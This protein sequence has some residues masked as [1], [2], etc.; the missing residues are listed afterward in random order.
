MSTDLAPTNG[1]LPALTF[2]PDQLDL[3]K[4]TIC[5]GATDDELALFL[6]TAK[7]TGL[8][9]LARQI[10][11]V[12][13]WDAKAQRE[14]MTLQTGIDG[15]RLIA[16]RSGQHAGTDDAQFALDADGHALSAS[17]TV[18]RLVVG[19]RVPFAATARFDEYAQRK[20][21]GSAT[22]MWAKMPFLMIAK[23]AE[24]LA[25]RKAFPAEL[26]GVYTTEEMTQADAATVIETPI[27]TP[28]P[29]AVAA[30]S[31]VFPDAA[32]VAPTP[33][34]TPATATLATKVNAALKEID[35]NQ[36]FAREEL[37][38]ALLTMHNRND[39]LA[40]T[41]LAE[42]STFQGTNGVVLGV[43]DV[44]QLKAKRLWVMHDKVM[45]LF[46]A[47][48]TEHPDYIP[49]TAENEVPCE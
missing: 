13:R 33:S 40:R 2:T 17:V 22:S 45:K 47:W 12:K 10:Y 43:R 49:P 42:L 30:V 16:Q 46:A 18:Y 28:T 37:W 38:S 34:S 44:W 7:R 8:D 1:T 32:P 11:A 3:I 24:A 25:L 23:C 20:K 4:R 29:A 19:Q 48:Q 26:S 36:A 35:Q 15:Y 41:A 21:D 27:T 5:Q 31:A 39:D 6:Y 9:P 14:I